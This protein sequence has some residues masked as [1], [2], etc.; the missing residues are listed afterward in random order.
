VPKT[1]IARPIANAII[2]I[3]NTDPP[4]TFS[5]HNAV[6]IQRNGRKNVRNRRSWRKRR[7]SGQN[8]RIETV[9]LRC[10][11]WMCCVK[12]KQRLW[13]GHSDCVCVV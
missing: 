6:Y 10:L 2:N 9:S 8:A 1:T 7:N 12:W 4:I 3:T 5:A 13:R 11:C